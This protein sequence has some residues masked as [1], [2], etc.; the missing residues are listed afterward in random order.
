MITNNYW[1]LTI[2]QALVNILQTLFHSVLTKNP[3]DN[4]YYHSNFT[5]K[6]NNYKLYKTFNKQLKAFLLDYSKKWKR[7]ESF[8][9]SF[10]KILFLK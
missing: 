3:H 8:L 10:F 1:I 9:F 6:K 2:C 7:K 4:N 5:D